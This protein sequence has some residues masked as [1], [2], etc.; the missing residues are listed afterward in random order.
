M[1]GPDEELDLGTALVRLAHLVNRVFAEVS[2]AHGLSPQQVQLLCRLAPGPVGMRDLCAALHLEKSSLS[3]LVDRI[4]R[5]GLVTRTPDAHDRRACR[6]ALTA[7]GLALGV[8]AHRAIITRLEQ[9]AGDSTPIE[10]RHLVAL[11]TRLL[12]TAPAQRKPRARWAQ[13]APPQPG[14][15]QPRQLGHPG[16]LVAR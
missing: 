9:L 2:R 6:I 5:R 14:T 16:G 8:R 13:P 12:H 15:A 1:N 3:G 11:T 10:R 4:E 7:K